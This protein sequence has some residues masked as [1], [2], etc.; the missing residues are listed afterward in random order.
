MDLVDAQQARRM[1]DRMV[2]YRI[3]PLLWEKVKRGL[4]AG[5]VQSV[6]L[7]IICDRE[8]E[9]EAFIP[10]EYW[11]LDALLNL[12]GEKKPLVARF[13]GKCKEKIEIHSKKE[14]DMILKELEGAQFK[15]KDIKTGERTKKAPVPFT[16]STLQQEASKQLT[17]STQKT[18]R[19]AQQPYEGIDI[20]GNGTVGLITYLR[21]DSIRISEEADTA[22]RL[23]L[24]HICTLCCPGGRDNKMHYSFRKREGRVLCPEDGCIYSSRYLKSLRYKYSFPW[25]SIV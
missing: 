7:R 22:V 17:Y 4:S 9:I 5:R 21:T 15:V 25:A 3:S 2:G 24:I 13:S 12:K 6:A 19:L 23:S 20:K 14:L 1:L 10:Q 18:M 8:K 16:T 11:S